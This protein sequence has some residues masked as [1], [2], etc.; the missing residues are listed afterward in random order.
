MLNE[1]ALELIKYAA[2]R[3]LDWL[4][5]NNY[6]LSSEQL[7]SEFRLS[8]PRLIDLR[9]LELEGT[10]LRELPPEIGHLINL[11]KLSVSA[12]QLRELP[13]EIG[14]LTNLQVLSLSS[15]QLSTLPREIG[16]LT[17][18]RELHLDS[19]QLR[20]LPP[21]IERLA[22]LQ[23]LSLSGNL[24]LP[25]AEEILS[26]HRN[27]QKI[28]NYYFQ[29]LKGRPI[30]EAKIIVIGESSV[31]KTS[32][33]KRLLYDTFDANEDKTHGIEI[34]P[35]KD[36]KVNDQTV[37]LNVWD[38]GGQE[39]MHATHQ[40]FFTN[41]TLYILV[42]N[43]REN[44]NDQRADYWLTKIRSLA[45]HS[46]VLVVGNKLD[47]ATSESN[48]HG[49]FQ[50]D[51][52][53]LLAKYGNIKG[54]YGICCDKK[55][56]EYDG[57]F[58]HFKRALVTQIGMLAE[59]HKPFPNDWFSMKEHLATM[60]EDFISYDEYIRRCEMR[61]ITKQ[62]D[63]ET[64]VEF[65][66]DL[67]I[68]LS[69]RKD[70]RLQ[71]T[72]VRNPKW[73]TKGV[74]AIVESQRVRDN[75][76]ILE[77][78]MLNTI[79]D[80]SA[81]PQQ[82][83]LYIIDMMRKF[84]LCYDITPDKKFLI[85]G[86]LP[87]R[88]PFIEEW[89]DTLN[90]QYKYETYFGSIVSRFIVKMHTRIDEHF[91]WLHGAILK[92]KENKALVKADPQEKTITISIRGNKFTSRDFLA[93]IRDKFDAIH[94]DFS[95]KIEERVPIPEH[96]GFYEDYQ[97]LLDLEAMR[98]DEVVPRG[99]KQIFD[100]KKLLNNIE[101]ENQRQERRENRAQSRKDYPVQESEERRTYLAKREKDS[102]LPIAKLQVEIEVRERQVEEL[103][104]KKKDC[105]DEAKF[106]PK[107][108]SSIF[109]IPLM[110][111]IG[112]L[113]YF[114]VSYQHLRSLLSGFSIALLVI[115][116]IWS[117][118]NLKEWSPTKFPE[119]LY[120]KEKQRLYEKFGFD[121]RELNSL[122]QELAELRA[123]QR[124]LQI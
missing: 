96:H 58:T 92:Y 36:V 71:D 93:M 46:P 49:K 107:F 65:L 45:K 91:V 64:L 97:H 117:A 51:E 110:L 14:H 50:V 74:Y 7:A 53:A 21:E 102:Y 68:V 116:Y 112:I 88:Q 95:M 81:Y 47:Q 100:V 30:N 10:Q 9:S 20:E 48:S 108:Y 83:H 77:L 101:S 89:K 118:V 70:S 69:F 62:L 41:R 56:G 61:G 11:R 13:P 86:S 42:V 19:N 44:Q 63:Q 119:Q 115:G 109:F 24:G 29:S 124:G 57:D 33:I 59:I 113:V 3:K 84:E 78:E 122:L 99:L 6:D 27:P 37:Q 73:V 5:L 87:I 35:W 2:E 12:N 34:Y 76:G 17:N 22:N 79:L 23:V 72:Q 16:H 39:L 111:V 75:N 18:L 103:K 82:K 15:N 120:E 40:F 8:A 66:H 98:R 52:Y 104:Q 60:P 85:P 114:A 32:L 26:D 67:G 1:K 123:G 4:N 55:R 94:D 90:F 121:E 38:F 106:K 80:R 31:G 25:I 28:L 54:F 105:D 43:A